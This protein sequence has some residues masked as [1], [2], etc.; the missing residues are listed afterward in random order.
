MIAKA[1]ADIDRD[2]VCLIDNFITEEARQTMVDEALATPCP[3]RTPTVLT[4]SVS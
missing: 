2:H 1:R 4:A 3:P